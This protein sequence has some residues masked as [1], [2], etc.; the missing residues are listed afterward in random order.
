[1][2]RLNIVLGDLYKAK[3]ARINNEF[4]LDHA[5]KEVQEIK[6]DL[7]KFIGKEQTDKETT[8]DH[9]SGTQESTSS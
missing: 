9:T 5:I 8:Y 2:R 7:E 1:M 6:A 4:H 3:Y